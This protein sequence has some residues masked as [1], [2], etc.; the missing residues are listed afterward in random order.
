MRLTASPCPP[1]FDGRG[2][3]EL[4]PA[5]TVDVTIDVVVAEATVSDAVPEEPAGV[6]GAEVETGF[7]GAGDER[8][9]CVGTRLTK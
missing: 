5:A 4:D 6:S 3:P 1:G 7:V 2:T 9:I 8:I